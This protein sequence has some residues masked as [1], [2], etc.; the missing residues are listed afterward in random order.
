[1]FCEKCGSPRV[2]DARFCEQ[3]G[4]PFE[5]AA[6]D[7]P[8]ELLPDPEPG[9]PAGKPM[10]QAAAP[11]TSEGALKSGKA[12][13]KPAGD[14]GV[15]AGAAEANPSDP[16]DELVRQWV[17][18]F[19]VWKN[20]AILI[21]TAKVLLLGLL[22]P[23]LLLFFLTLGDGLDEALAVAGNILGYGLLILAVL[24]AIA[25]IL[26]G[27]IYGGKYLVLFQMDDTGVDHIQLQS[28]VKR[29]EA[30]GLLAALA[31]AASGNVT[32]TG[33]GIM[34]ASR[35]HLR[36]DFKKVRSIKAVR[37]RNTIYLNE[38]VTRN[39]I[40]PETGRFDEVL[41][42]IIRHSPRTVRVTGRS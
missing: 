6:P 41:D 40:Y 30:L 8:V 31:G 7:E 11:P 23:T 15:W 4:T 22:A 19:S 20:P 16:S 37:S 35:S 13:E 17:Y 42:H 28:Q 21:T 9:I 25:Y 24:L 1:M 27:L 34:A 32:A 29:A 14:R 33:A 36:T 2:G 38:S 10:K 18:E 3:C 26:V 12:T 39:Q 5:V